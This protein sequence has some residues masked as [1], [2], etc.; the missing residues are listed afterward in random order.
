MASTHETRFILTAKDKTKGAFSTVKGSLKGIAVGTAQLTGAIAG[1]AGAAGFGLLGRGLIDTNI[2][3]QTMKSSLK[4]LTGSADEAGRTFDEIVR[5]ATTTPFALEEVTGAFIKL[6]ALGLDPSAEAITSYGNT[7]SAMGKSLDQ[8]IEAVADASTGEFE[9]LKEFGI[10]ASSQGDQV[11]LTFQGVATTIG[12]NAE[13][14]TGYLQSIGRVNF[15]GAM[16]D[17]MNNVAPAFDNFATAIDL[18]QVKIGEAGLNAT[19]STTVNN[20]TDLINA[21]DASKVAAFTG[22]ALG[23]LASMLGAIDSITDGIGRLIAGDFTTGGR[24]GF[25]PGAGDIGPGAE[26]YLLGDFNRA[27]TG[28]PALERIREQQAGLPNQK[29]KQL[30]EQTG[31]LRQIADGITNAVEKGAAVAG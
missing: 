4:T 22:D 15:A 28:Q 29:N 2:Q 3:F 19:I 23:G 17:Q 27:Q 16:S 30:D 6:K 11:T 21:M 18:L 24:S 13:E 12:K 9:R 14:I 7:A 1:L 20:M 31:L 5:F 10:K 8:M 25:L 26:D